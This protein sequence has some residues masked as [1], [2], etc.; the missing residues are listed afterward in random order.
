MKAQ[1]ASAVISFVLAASM[2]VWAADSTHS[3]ADSARRGWHFYREPAPDAD[4]EEVPQTRPPAETPHPPPLVSS[5]PSAPRRIE[6][7][8]FEQLQKRVEELRNVAIMRPTQDN[9]LR[10][11]DLEAAV[12]RRASYFADVAQRVAWAH[13]E[14]DMTLEGRP[15][16]AQAIDV[17]DRQQASERAGD[18]KALGQD[19]VLLFFFRSDCPYCHSF[20]PTLAEFSERYGISVVAVSIDGGGLP[21]FPG[22]RTDNGIARRL[23][24]TTVP[25]VLLAQPS[26]GQIKPIGFGPLSEAQ[27]LERLAAVRR[28]IAERPRPQSASS[29]PLGSTVGA[30]TSGSPLAGTLSYA[31]SEP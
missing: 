30:K 25:T 22:Y 24:V 21:G 29:D 10:Y 23:Q 19:H 26:T 7:V 8:E 15:V 4:S 13:P 14:L 3:D 20:A 5:A 17:F 12:V 31:G 6:L 11:M 16:N 18:V 27:L 28:P 1:T 9:V 2:D